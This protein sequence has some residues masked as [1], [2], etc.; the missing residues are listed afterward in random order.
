MSLYKSPFP[1]LAKSVS[2]STYST[3]SG[4]DLAIKMAEM[5]VL[6]AKSVMKSRP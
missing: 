6:A 2:A 1:R 5:G 4:T 3:V